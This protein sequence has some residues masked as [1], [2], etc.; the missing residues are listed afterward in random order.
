[1]KNKLTQLAKGIYNVKTWRWTVLVMIAVLLCGAVY[2]SINFL[3]TSRPHVTISKKELKKGKVNKDLTQTDEVES[4]ATFEDFNAK[5][6]ALSRKIPKR[7][8]N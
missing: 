5:Y 8:G 6:K 4:E 7:S 1:M 2:Y 3:E